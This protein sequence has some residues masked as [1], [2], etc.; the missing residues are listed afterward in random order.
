MRTPTVTPLDTTTLPELSLMQLWKYHARLYHEVMQPLRLEIET[1]WVADKTAKGI[2]PWTDPLYC[3]DWLAYYDT[4]TKKASY[5]RE[6]GD[7]DHQ[8]WLAWHAGRTQTAA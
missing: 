4:L 2:A 7:H 1:R 6:R 5:Y 3:A 8:L